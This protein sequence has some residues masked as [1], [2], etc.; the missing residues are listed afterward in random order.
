MRRDGDVAHQNVHDN[1]LCG[2]AEQTQ[3]SNYALEGAE[4]AAFQ[5]VA[6]VEKM[7]GTARVVSLD[8]I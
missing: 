4:S 2:R 7:S 8:L 5:I 6:H 1:N 3:A